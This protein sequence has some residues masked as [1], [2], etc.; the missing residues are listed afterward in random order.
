MPLLH[1]IL[2]AALLL[3]LSATPLAAQASGGLALLREAAQV[4]RALAEDAVLRAYPLDTDAVGGR[5][6]LRG[7]VRTAEERQRAEALASATAASAVQNAL[8]L[9][10]EA[11]LDPAFRTKTDAP[12]PPIPTPEPRPEPIT[13]P[14]P[15]PIGP[16][17]QRPK[18]V[19]ETE[20]KPSPAPAASNEVYH[21]VESGD[22]LYAIARQYS[23][24]V[25]AIQRLNGIRGSRIKPGQKLRVK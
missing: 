10:P 15:K 9:D 7:A 16:P 18:P 13:A 5:I 17:E 21:T 3:V 4:E 20:P 19:A 8:T 14:A 22:S 1:P 2:I 6:V 23:T 24:S 25:A 12:P 11:G